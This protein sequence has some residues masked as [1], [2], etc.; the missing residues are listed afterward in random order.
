MFGHDDQLKVAP[1]GV[2]K[3]HKDID[4]LKLRSIAVVKKRV[5]R[6]FPLLFCDSDACGLQF[7]G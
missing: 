3:D 2:A 1:K 4:L 7:Y 6:T 5:L